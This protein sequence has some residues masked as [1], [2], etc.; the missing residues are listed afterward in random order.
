MLVL[1]ATANDVKLVVRL[2]LMRRRIRYELEL[3]GT[4]PQDLVVLHV[5]ETGRF[6]LGGHQSSCVIDLKT[7][8]VEHGF[9]H[10]LFW[11]F[12]RQTRPGF[13]L[14]TGELDCLFRALDGRVLGKVP[15]DPPWLMFEEP[16]GL[17]FESIVHG[18]QFLPFPR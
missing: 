1:D 4:G 6:F 12:D 8:T 18:S 3:R 16:G 14:E 5:E 17:R 13:V 11:G 7:M 15:V 9:E 10:C 2:E